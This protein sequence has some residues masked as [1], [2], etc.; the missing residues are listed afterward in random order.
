[1][2]DLNEPN[3]YFI[4]FMCCLET[5]ILLFALGTKFLQKKHKMLCHLGVLYHLVCNE[6][7]LQTSVSKRPIDQQPT[8]TMLHIDVKH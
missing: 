5:N 2:I 7:W 1:M 3:L 8:F 4:H 6:S